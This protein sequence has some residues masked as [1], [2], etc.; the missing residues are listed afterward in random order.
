MGSTAEAED[1]PMQ[2]V[3]LVEKSG[4]HKYFIYVEDSEDPSV[5][6]TTCL[7]RQ[8]TVRNQIVD[9]GQSAI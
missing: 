9:A 3:A 7:I 8:T 1:Q 4:P 2:Q 5:V 6:C